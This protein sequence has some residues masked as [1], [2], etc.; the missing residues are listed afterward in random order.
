MLD[1]ARGLL[2]KRD[3]TDI[4]LADVAQAAGVAT[5]SAYVFYADIAELIASL[6]TQ[7][8][9]ELIYILQRPLRFPIGGWQD[10]VV[11]L[12]GRG[13]RFYNSD[14][15]ARQLQ[16]GP[17]T[18]P[19]LKLRDRRSDAAIGRV[20]EQHIGRHFVLPEFP[21]RAQVFFRAVEIADLMFCLSLVDAA[22]ITT[23]MRAEADRACIA[24]L[25]TYLPAALAR[26]R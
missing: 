7:I 21:Q 23:G 25:G 1:A 16:V 3:L 9:R 19:E 26:R 15:A 24:Y 5:S 12:N 22:A 13:V 2:A 8:Q 4:A 14:A 20:Y 10:I 6:Q 11:K 17:H 18:P